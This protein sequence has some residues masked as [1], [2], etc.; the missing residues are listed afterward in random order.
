MFHILGRRLSAWFLIPFLAG[1]VL[2]AP[3]PGF[4]ADAPSGIGYVDLDELLQ[5]YEEY[6]KV[7]K[8]FDSYQ[9][10][11]KERINA[12][13]YLTWDEW[14]QLDQLEGKEG[15]G[16]KL[17][18]DEKKELE[19]LRKLSEQ[20]DTRLRDLQGLRDP[21][22]DQKK[23]RQDLESLEKGNISRIQEFGKSLARDGNEK[24]S[25]LLNDLQQKVK[26]AIADIAEAKG[27][28]VVFDRKMLLWVKGNLEITQDVVKKLNSP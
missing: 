13:R 28:S 7:D 24:F 14:G 19:R 12:R 25:K 8:E 18:D 16:E 22:E 11:G 23:E 26:K 2:C 9:Q 27:L 4:T 17:K 5:K 6:Q 15:K 21:N 20:R 1:L 10:S 3:P